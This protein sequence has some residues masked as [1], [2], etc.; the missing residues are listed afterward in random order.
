MYA[1]KGVDRGLREA[2]TAYG[3]LGHAMIQ[4]SDDGTTYTAGVA[5][6]KAKYWETRYSPLLS[7]EAFIDALAERF[8]F[9][10][11]ASTGQLLPQVN[12]GSRLTE[13]PSAFPIAVELDPALIG[14]GWVVDGEL[15]LDEVDFEA[16]RA[17]VGQDWLALKAVVGEENAR[18]VVWTGRLDV[19]GSVDAGGRDLVVGRGYGVAS[20]LSE[21][22]ADRPPTIFFSDGSTVHGTVVVNSRFRTRALPTMDYQFP[23]WSGVDIRAETRAK[24]SSNGIGCSINE[25]LERYVKAQPRRGRH[26]WLIHND[27]GGEFADYIVIEVD[28]DDVAVG[29][30]HAKYAGG[31]VPSVRV[32]DLQ[33]VVAQGIK[34]RR[35]ITDPGFWAEL[36]KRLTGQAS[37]KATVQDGSLEQLLVLCGQAGRAENLSFTRTRPV[38]RGTIAIVQPGLSYSKLRAGLDDEQLSAVQ[39]R[40]LLAVFH[41]SVS[42]VASTLMVCS[43]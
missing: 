23:N 25:A 40:D 42:Q 35:W 11:G 20:P 12:R 15:S 8:W 28:V 37:P 39:I 9:P 18:R 16:E 7:Y 43:E 22:L 6:S 5:T 30:W 2:D 36:G 31:D 17:T 19:T 32:G 10:P 26:R 27:G 38:V 34:S 24:A 33:E 1:G 41:D 13:W 3:S 21:L 4:V 14:M 29:L